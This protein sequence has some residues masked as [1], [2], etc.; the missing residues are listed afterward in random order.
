MTMGNLLAWSKAVG[1]EVAAGDILCEIETDKS[2]VSRP[3]TLA[4]GTR[5]RSG[6]DGSRD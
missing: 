4:F 5:G 1:D 6:G 2:T 3:G